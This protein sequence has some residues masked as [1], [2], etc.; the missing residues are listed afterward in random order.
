MRIEI[1]GYEFSSGPIS[2]T[3]RL[4][5]TSPEGDGTEIDELQLRELFDKFF[6]EVM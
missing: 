6:K 3:G 5:M 1:A 4:F 2:K